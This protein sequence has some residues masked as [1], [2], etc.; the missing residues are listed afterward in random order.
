MVKS[1]EAKSGS[2]VVVGLLLK[3]AYCTLQAITG[4]TLLH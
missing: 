4:Y 1:C 3:M 2:T